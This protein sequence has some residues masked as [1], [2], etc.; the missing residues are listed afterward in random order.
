MAEAPYTVTFVQH[1]VHIVEPLVENLTLIKD[2]QQLVVDFLGKIL[3]TI[4]KSDV[5]I[6]N[7][8]CV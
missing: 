4:T 3:Y 5:F 8:S 6:N 2:V 7:L 1:M